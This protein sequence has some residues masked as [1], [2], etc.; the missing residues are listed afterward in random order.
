[1]A[2]ITVICI[3]VFTGKAAAYWDVKNVDWVPTLNLGHAKYDVEA[4]SSKR[5][6]RAERLQQRKTKIAAVCNS[7]LLIF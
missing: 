2:I 3:I 1:M 5:S 7:V 4:S 6:E